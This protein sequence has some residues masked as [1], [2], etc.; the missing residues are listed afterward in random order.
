MLLFISSHLAGPVPMASTSSY[1][2]NGLPAC[3]PSCIAFRVGL[4]LRD[5]T[6]LKILYSLERERKVGERQSQPH[7]KQHQEDEL[8]P[9]SCSQLL[10]NSTSM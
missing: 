4:Q 6:W 1:I 9:S 7:R 5:I 8:T 2:V 10:C 3:S